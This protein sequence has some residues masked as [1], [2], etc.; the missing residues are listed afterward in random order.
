MTWERFLTW[1]IIK[2]LFPHWA[3]FMYFWVTAPYYQ[4][5]INIAQLK[6]RPGGQSRIGTYHSSA[7]MLLTDVIHPNPS[8]P[9]RMAHPG[10]INPVILN[11]THDFMNW[12]FESIVP[13]MDYIV[14]SFYVI[15]SIGWGLNIFFRLL[16]VR[17]QR[18]ADELWLL[19]W[20]PPAV[21]TMITFTGM[22]QDHCLNGQSG[23]IEVLFSPLT[24][25]TGIRLSN[26]STIVYS[27][28]SNISFPKTSV[29]WFQHLNQ[30]FQASVQS[31]KMIFAKLWTSKTLCFMA[32]SVL[33][34]ASLS[35]STVDSILASTFIS[36]GHD[37][38]TAVLDNSATAHILMIAAC[39]SPTRH[40]TRV[41]ALSRRLVNI[42]LQQQALVPFVFRGM[43]MIIP[44]IHM[45]CHT[46]SIFQN[47]RSI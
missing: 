39:L 4:S 12:Y 40:W 5:P 18:K 2:L 15:L 37:S 25:R 1:N 46:C 11:Q 26:S 6:C 20:P 13:S 36:F 35:T 24:R 34:V 21:G 31:S 30:L 8:G 27:K 19:Y 32:Y 10:A 3:L 9:F 7:T 23:T 45:T 28:W 33:V 41:K 17:L 22:T 47:L 38:C 42:L 43:M 14:H 29:N 44:C 16:G